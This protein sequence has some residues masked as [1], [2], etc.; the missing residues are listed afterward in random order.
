[1]SDTEGKSITNQVTIAEASLSIG[2]GWRWSNSHDRFE[3]L[4]FQGHNQ[5]DGWRR[6]LVEFSYR[7]EGTSCT[8]HGV[9]WIWWYG[10]D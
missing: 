10:M 9:T 8:V 5:F 2:F 7:N 3:L 4:P 6:G 1:L